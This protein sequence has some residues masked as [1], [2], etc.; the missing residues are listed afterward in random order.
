M[1]NR[2][3]RITLI[4]VIGMLVFGSIAASA[5]NCERRVRNAEMQLQRAVA[6]HGVNSRQAEKK[7][8]HLEQVRATCH[9]R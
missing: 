3:Q 8:R 9:W 4:G 7:R 1:L 6:R 2:L 5:A